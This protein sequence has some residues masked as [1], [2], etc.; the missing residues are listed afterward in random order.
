[1]PRPL[2]P[3]QGINIPTV[4]L[5]DKDIPAA[6]RDTWAQLRALAWGRGETPELS[7]NQI[8]EI[9][10]KTKS[11]LYE[12]MRLLRLRAVLSWRAGSQATYIVV[13]FPDT[14]RFSENLEKP[15][16]DMYIEEES[17]LIKDNHHNVSE[18]LENRKVPEDDLPV[19]PLAPFQAEF[20]AAT[21]LPIDFSP[22]QARALKEIMDLGARPGDITEACS[23]LANS[24]RYRITGAW[25]LVNT[26]RSLIAKRSAK[27]QPKRPKV[28]PR[29]TEEYR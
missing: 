9:T 23:I 24:D 2:L 16:N 8:A 22:K 12:H 18:N 3:P 19:G 10:G 20:T 17:Q 27:M 28:E 1:M 7:I 14:F 4:V 29:F 26:I 25:S 11:T 21:S 13:S 15:Y 5:F 6:V